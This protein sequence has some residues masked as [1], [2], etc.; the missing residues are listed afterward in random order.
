M[1]PVPFIVTRDPKVVEDIFS[2]PDCHNKSQHIVN[3][4]TSCMGNG[5][6]GKQGAYTAAFLTVDQI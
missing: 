4:I 1:G 2:S 6:L 5:L 3:A